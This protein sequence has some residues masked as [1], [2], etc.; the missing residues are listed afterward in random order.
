MQQKRLNVLFIASWFPNRNHS[1]IGNFIQRHAEVANL[2]ANISVLFATSEKSLKKGF[3]VI[4]TE[5]K[6][7]SITRVYYKKVRSK[8][9]FLNTWLKKR[10]YLAAIETGRNKI[11]SNIDIVHVNTF[12]FGGLAGL[13]V[14][15]KTGIPY[16]LTEHWS[17][18]LPQ[19]NAYKRSSVIMKIMTK[20]IFKNAKL[21]LPVSQDLGENLVKKNLIQ[22]FQV[23]PNVVDENLFKPTKSVRRSKKRFIHVSTINEEHKNFSGI[24]EAFKFVKEPYQLVVITDGDLETAK[25]KI[26]H[27]QLSDKVILHGIKSPEQVA[28]ELT[29]VDCL[30]QFS[31]VET[32][33]IVIAEAWM[34]GIPCIYSKCGGLTNIQDPKLGIQIKSK[35]TKALTSSIEGFIND[36]FEYSSAEIRSFAEK[37][38]SIKAVSKKFKD[39]YCHLSD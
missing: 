5:E 31:N 26:E 8:I 11:T 19:N 16:V 36:K 25:S 18:F 1:T 6:G 38:F 24:L 15:K 2:E 32:F 3:E 7:V 4:Q 27:F 39:V 13:D 17:G 20:K 29:K 14:L 12:W 22:D 9:P 10:K 35:D 21:V 30:I 37:N 34:S 33:S 28:I 23:L